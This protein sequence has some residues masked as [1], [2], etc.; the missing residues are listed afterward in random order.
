LKNFDRS[1]RQLM[2]FTTG[3]QDNGIKIAI[4]DTGCNTDDDFF[5]GPGIDHIDRFDDD[6]S[7]WYDC[8]GESDI[9]VDEDDD[10]HGTALTALLLRLAPGASIYVIRIARNSHELSDSADHIKDVSFASNSPTTISLMIPTKAI[11]YATTQGIDI[12]SMSFGFR[13]IQD[14]V[15]TALTNAGSKMMFFAAANNDGLNSREMFPAHHR[16]VISVRGTTYNGFFE[17]QYNPITWEEGGLHY[18]TLAV[19]VPCGWPIVT[20]LKKSGCSIATPIMV[21]IA[22]AIIA[23]VDRDDVPQKHTDAWRR[24]RDAIRTQEGML[25]IFRKMTEDQAG[26]RRYLAPWQL[27][28][29]GDP[30]TMIYYALSRLRPRQV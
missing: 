19:D 7:L 13:T 20:R 15:E 8:L 22:A 10:N 1:I 17:Q 12:L 27:Y 25:S 28:E 21:A 2:T 9:P 26:D 6:P 14:A 18:G 11:T 24:P 29:N 23:F 4:L 16:S 5:N 30:R 3:T